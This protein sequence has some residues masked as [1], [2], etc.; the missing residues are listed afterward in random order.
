[1]KLLRLH[2]TLQ[3]LYWRLFILFYWTKR[4]HEAIQYISGLYERRKQNNIVR[5]MPTWSDC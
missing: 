3:L 5:L 2:E 4:M 1:M